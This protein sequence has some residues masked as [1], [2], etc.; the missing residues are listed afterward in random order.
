MQAGVDDIR[1]PGELAIE[2]DSLILDSVI[3][4]AQGDGV[5]PITSGQRGKTADVVKREP[6]LAR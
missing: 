4:T 5:C 2:C 3:F 1:A 6:V